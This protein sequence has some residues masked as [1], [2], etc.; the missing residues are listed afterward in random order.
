MKRDDA[1]QLRRDLRRILPMTASVYKANFG[2]FFLLSAPV[3]P[4]DI[5]TYV[6]TDWARDPVASERPVFVAIL[7]IVQL[8]ATLIAS[9]AIVA[10]AGSI[11]T[12]RPVGIVQ[13]YSLALDRFATA[14]W[15]S[16][17]ACLHVL[18][19]AV[20]VMGIPWA[21]QRAVRWM[22]I[23]QSVILEGT[24]ARHTLSQ[25]AAVIGGP[26]SW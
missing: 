2:L 21:V 20:T 12:L 18:L 11:V 3:I 15:A 23:E 5:G 22:F 24:N 26:H 13:A 19:F 9:L 10:A 25:S 16:L 8:A 14:W 6:V 1:D 4:I 7:A 17:R